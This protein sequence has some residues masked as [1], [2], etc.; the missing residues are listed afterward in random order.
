MVVQDPCHSKPLSLKCL[1][2]NVRS[3]NNKVDSVLKYMIK[4]NISIAFI[5][6]TWLTDL[7]N[8]TTASIKAYGYNIHH[9]YRDT[10]GGG[11]ALLY[12]PA[13]KVVK[14][15]IDN[16]LSFESIS[17]KVKLP[18]SKYLLCS[19]IMYIQNRFT[20]SILWWTRHIDWQTIQYVRKFV[21]LLGF[22]YPYGWVFKYRVFK[23]QWNYWFIW[24][25]PIGW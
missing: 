25:I 5:Q 7:N 14:L 13:I 23:T 19:C 17:I 22:Q 12:I 3:L 9:F 15:F 8:H 2:W 21:D 20:S 4:E 24:I 10:T 16:G 6:E 1:S 11:V 18:N